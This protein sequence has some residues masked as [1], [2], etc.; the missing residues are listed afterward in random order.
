MK[1]LFTTLAATLALVTLCFSLAACSRLSGTYKGTTGTYVFSG[2]KVT[3]TR[4]EGF[5]AKLEDKC[6]YEIKKG[7]DGKQTIVLNYLDENDSVSDTREYSFN[8]GK[9]NDGEFIEIAGV[10]L[11]KQ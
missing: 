1:K 9:D 8:Q 2:N 4:A 11:I 3:I 5:G 10:K 6:T 7:D